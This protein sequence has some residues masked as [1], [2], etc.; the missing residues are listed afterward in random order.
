MRCGSWVV[1]SLALAACG[2]SSAATSDV[3][4]QG[5]QTGSLECGAVPS[6]REPGSVPEGDSAFVIDVGRCPLPLSPSDVTIKDATGQQLGVEL[7]QLDSGHYLVRTDGALAAGQYEVTT[8]AGAAATL[9]VTEAVSLPSSLGELSVTSAGCGAS[10]EL[11]LADEAVAYASLMQL[12]VRIDGGEP[13]PLVAP[14][15]LELDAGVALLTLSRCEFGCLADGEHEVEVIAEIAGESAQPEPVSATFTS[16]C[17]DG[18]NG[19]RLSSGDARRNVPR[20]HGLALFA[21][22]ML[23]RLRR[24]RSTPRA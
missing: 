23:A 2:C 5:G 7:E 24:R 15:E 3:D 8:P 12:Q 16:E 4:H 11:R 19:C 18:A 20:G 9:T 22:A 21:L 13:M 10:F 1:G 6:L 14:G 17:P